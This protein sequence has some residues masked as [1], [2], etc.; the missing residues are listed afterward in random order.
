MRFPAQA[1]EPIGH[2]RAT[3]SCLTFDP[4]RSLDRVE[5]VLAGGLAAEFLARTPLAALT[6][7]HVALSDA[8]RTAHA[9]QSWPQA[10]AVL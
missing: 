7:G 1:A 2:L 3:G 4:R 5:A 6:A 9:E 8:S 10:P